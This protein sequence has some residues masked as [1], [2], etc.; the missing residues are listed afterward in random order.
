M[1][2]RPRLAWIRY[3]SHDL[4]DE[5][6]QEAAGKFRVAIIQPWELK[7]AETLKELDSDVIVLAYQCLSSVRVYEKGPI[8]SSGISPGQA[9][10]L[11]S[12]ALNSSRRRIEWAG[13]PGHFQQEVWKPEY[14]ERWVKTVVKRFEHTPFDGVFA[15]NDVYDDYYNLNFP[16]YGGEEITTVHAALDQL[17]RKAGEALRGVDKLLV[18]NIAEARR[19]KDR[20]L[21]HSRYG[22]G[23]EECWMGW[24]N[25]PETRLNYR[26][27]WQQMRTLRAPGVSVARTPGTGEPGDPN[28]LLALAAA[29]VFAP[30]SDVAVS[31]TAHDGYNA[32]PWREEARWDLGLPT[33]ARPLNPAPGVYIRT[34]DKGIAAVNLSHQSRP[35]GRHMLEPWSGFMALKPL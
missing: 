24:D 30:T 10:Q 29:W 1:R 3:G 11:G 34:L 15:D 4:T 6:I 28:L 23:V 7:A 16:L 13:Y 22:G 8:Y 35:L 5:E 26:A 27:I 31:A 9:E 2:Y 21:R 12:F 19:E 33:H 14:Q 18:P 32:M 20:W 17:V 25:S